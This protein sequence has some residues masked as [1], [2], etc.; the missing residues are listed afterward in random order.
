[1]GFGH[2]FRQHM[3]LKPS[4]QSLF[5]TTNCG[6]LCRQLSSQWSVCGPSTH[7][8]LSI[9]QSRTRLFSTF[10]FH[11]VVYYFWANWCGTVYASDGSHRPWIVEFVILIAS[12]ADHLR[13]KFVM[14]HMI[15]TVRTCICMGDPWVIWIIS[16]CMCYMFVHIGSASVAK[17]DAFTRNWFRR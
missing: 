11:T 8:A 7:I 9:F 14:I 1:M 6:K 4:E 17:T 2:R 16:R 12:C 10:M 13:G 5:F 15:C 3:T